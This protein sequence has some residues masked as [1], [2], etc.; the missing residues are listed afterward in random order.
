MC[1]HELINLT[2]NFG[3][4]G[5]MTARACHKCMKTTGEIDLEQQLAAAKAELF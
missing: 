3:K 1:E 4:H 2:G 5:A